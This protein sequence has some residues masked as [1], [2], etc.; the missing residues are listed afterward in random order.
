MKVRNRRGRD[1][2]QLRAPVTARDVTHSGQRSHLDSRD[3]PAWPALLPFAAYLLWWGL[4]LG[5]FVWIVAGGVMVLFWV[6]VKGFRFPPTF[7]IWA[8]F[9]GWVIVSLSMVDTPGRMVGALYRLLLY[10][11]ATAFCLHVYNARRTI[12]LRSVTSAMAWFLAGMTVAGIAAMILPEAV[13]RTP[14]SFLVPRALLANEMV[15]DMVIRHLSQWKADAWV[16]QAVRPAAPFLYANTWGNVYSLVLPLVMLHF[17]IVRHENWGKWTALLIVASMVPALATLNRGMFVGL[18][19]TAAWVMI[20]AVRRGRTGHVVTGVLALA[21]AGFAVLISPFGQA[22][23]HRVEVTNSTTDREKLYVLTVE[24]VLKSPALGYGSPRPSPFPWIPS[25]GTQGQLWTVMYSHGF[26]GAAL[27]IGFFAI[28]FLICARRV[29]T[30]GAVLGGVIL[31]TLVETAF[32]G[33]MT[34]IMV[35]MVAVALVLRGDTFISSSDPRE[36]IGRSGA[37]SRSRGR[38]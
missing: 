37:R 17:W 11:A 12:T 1:A 8:L 27:F 3:L 25:F 35:S 28:V 22:F 18:G 6:G 38:R 29:D 32:Y 9:I 10:M 15:G 5:D 4:G 19:V 23:T 26:I 34:G 30:A 13:F 16:P 31:A 2:P 24:E 33:M 7:L 36:K 20:Q 14:L 21:A